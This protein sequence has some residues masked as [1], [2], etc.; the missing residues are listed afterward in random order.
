MIVLA[1][2]TQA[3]QGRREPEYLEGISA[4]ENEARRSRFAARTR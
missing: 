4:T 2:E 3:S 1:S